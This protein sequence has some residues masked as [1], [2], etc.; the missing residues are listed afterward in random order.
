M[1]P[2][3]DGHTASNATAKRC[4]ESEIQKRPNFFFLAFSLQSWKGLA[5]LEVGERVQRL[6]V[7]SCKGQPSLVIKQRAYSFWIVGLS[8]TCCWIVVVVFVLNANFVSK[9]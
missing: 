2:L 8:S 5:L 6:R 7:R 3:F 9:P 1:P 4:Q